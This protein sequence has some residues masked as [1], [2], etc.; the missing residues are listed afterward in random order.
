MLKYISPYVQIGFFSCVGNDYQW[1]SWCRMYKRGL[2][3]RYT[4]AVVPSL[5]TDSEK[6]GP[7]IMEIPLDQPAGVADPP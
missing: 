7:V 6:K 2:H 1:S 3:F 5:T 4:G